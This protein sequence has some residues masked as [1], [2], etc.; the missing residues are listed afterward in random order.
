[1]HAADEANN[2]CVRIVLEGNLFI[3]ERANP[4]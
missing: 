4:P 1:M 2:R 3:L